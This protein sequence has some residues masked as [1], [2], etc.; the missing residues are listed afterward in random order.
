LCNIE[1]QQKSGVRLNVLQKWE[2]ACKKVTRGGKNKG[3]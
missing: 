2:L 3:H 1:S